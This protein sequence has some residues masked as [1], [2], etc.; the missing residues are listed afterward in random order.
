VADSKHGDSAH[1]QFHRVT[2]H[3][4]GTEGSRFE[5]LAGPGTG[6]ITEG[7]HILRRWNCPEWTALIDDSP[8]TLLACYDG[9][10]GELESL[11]LDRSL[12]NRWLIWHEP[13]LPWWWSRRF[14]AR[15]FA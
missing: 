5:I 7:E 10:S 1:Q 2:G 13:T 4:L 8:L 15:W 12:E 11:S 3:R 9:S 14:S 6:T